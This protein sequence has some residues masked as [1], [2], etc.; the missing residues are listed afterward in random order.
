[1]YYELK[2]YR[3]TRTGVNE[4]INTHASSKNER[5]IDPRH[6]TFLF[7]APP[8]TKANLSYEDSKFRG[9]H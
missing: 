1:M 9:M 7:G 6:P 8:L 2:Y 5:W 4:Q 3:Q